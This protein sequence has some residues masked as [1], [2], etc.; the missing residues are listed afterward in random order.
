VVGSTWQASPHPLAYGATLIVSRSVDGFLVDRF[1]VEPA[2]HLTPRAIAARAEALP[3][4]V[5]SFPGILVQP[6]SELAR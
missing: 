5:R 2:W 3:G 4:P 6:A 1:L